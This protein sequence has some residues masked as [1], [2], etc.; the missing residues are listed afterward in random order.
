MA[1]ID[2]GA[3]VIKNGKVIDK[4]MF[5]YLTIQKSIKNT[6]YFHRKGC[7]IIKEINTGEL[8]DAG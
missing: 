2:Y 7:T 6:L 3:V 1:M 8:V 4:N 5:G